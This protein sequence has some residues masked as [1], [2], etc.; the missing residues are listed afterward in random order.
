MKVVTRLVFSSTALLFATLGKA[1]LE[2]R[3]RFDK[4][5]S[6]AQSV[7]RNQWSQKCGYIKSQAMLNAMNAEGTY[8]VFANARLGN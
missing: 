4:L 3:C 5:A 6:K 1:D 8:L 7:G 2:D